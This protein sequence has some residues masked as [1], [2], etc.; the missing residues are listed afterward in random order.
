M[1]R[2]NKHA[3]EGVFPSRL[4]NSDAS[5]SAR[6]RLGAGTDEPTRLDISCGGHGFG[7]GPGDGHSVADIVTGAAPTVDSKPLPA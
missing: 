6:N 2:E 5:P 1:L 3:V 4:P 7:I